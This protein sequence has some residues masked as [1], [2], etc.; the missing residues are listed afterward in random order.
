MCRFARSASESHPIYT[1]FTP[2]LHRIYTGF[3][4]DLH[5]KPALPAPHLYC[6]RFTPDLHH[7]GGAAVLRAHPLCLSLTVGLRG[8]KWD[9]IH[10]SVAPSPDPRPIHTGPRPLCHLRCSR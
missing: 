6:T 1:G 8:W 7:T 9:H 10:P 2:D 5:L 3:T 4:P